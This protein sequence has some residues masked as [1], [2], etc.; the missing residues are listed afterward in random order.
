[1]I[2][3]L[4]CFL[5]AICPVQTESDISSL[6]QLL[7]DGQQSLDE[8][9]R[10]IQIIDDPAQQIIA[11]SDYEGGVI[12]FSLLKFPDYES[13]SSYF[14]YDDD[15][16][17]YFDIILEAYAPFELQNNCDDGTL[18]IYDFSGEFDN[19]NYHMR[20]YF[21]RDNGD[22]RITGLYF[23]V[24]SA[25]NIDDYGAGFYSEMNSCLNSQSR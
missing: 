9:W 2:Q 7:I 19:Q 4:L 11:F 3:L 24:D 20:I 14:S 12:R 25:L 22:I 15:M 10:V 1:M 6:A 21:E 13:E 5:F 18:A 17:P 16:Q 23:P 8:Q